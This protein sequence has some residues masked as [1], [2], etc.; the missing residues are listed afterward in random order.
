MEAG[1]HQDEGRHERDV[2]AKVEARQRHSPQREAVREV[3]GAR[4]GF[5]SAQ[6]LYGE[7]RNAGSSIGLATVYR[8]VQAMLE[9]GE[10]DVLHTREGE[11]LYRQCSTRHHHHL[12]CR[13]CGKAVEITAPEIEAWAE[14]TAAEHGFTEID[15]S[16]EIYGLCRNC[17]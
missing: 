12:I 8:H 10:L 14:K 13:N 16:V 17:S 1:L 7:L 4:S 6:D 2:M 5:V 3:L 15:H 11:A 9:S